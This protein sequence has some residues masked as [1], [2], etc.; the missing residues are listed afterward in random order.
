MIKITKNLKLN[1]LMII[2]LKIMKLTITVKYNK[3]KI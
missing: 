1:I 2:I 3:V